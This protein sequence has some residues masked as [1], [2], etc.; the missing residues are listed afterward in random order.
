MV[1]TEY[2]MN[3][4]SC[5]CTEL[6]RV[7]SLSC[8]QLLQSTNSIEVLNSIAI[9]SVSSLLCYA[10]YIWIVPSHFFLDGFRVHSIFS[11]YCLP[12]F[13]SIQGTATN[14]M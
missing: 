3:T 4:G 9:A 5:L 8:M 13:F 10:K 7:K 14:N 2:P 6:C 11:N 1:I 12:S